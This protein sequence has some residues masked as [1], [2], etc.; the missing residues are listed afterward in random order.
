MSNDVVSKAY[1]L[2]G[3]CLES[4]KSAVNVHASN[5]NKSCLKDIMPIRLCL[6]YLIV[7]F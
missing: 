3:A 6:L 4:P 7:N 1:L 2:D 5:S